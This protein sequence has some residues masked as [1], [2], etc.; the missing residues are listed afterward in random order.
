MGSTKKKAV[1]KSERFTETQNQETLKKAST[2]T[3]ESVVDA[4]TKAQVAIS[5]KLSEVN[6][7]LQTQLAELN[8]VSQAVEVKN[9]ELETIYSKEQ[10]LKNIDELTVEF[11]QHQQNIED[12]KLALSREREQEEADF[13]F[14][15][16]QLRKTEQVQYE[17]ERR[18]LKNAHRDE[19]EARNKAFQLRE[20]T[21]KKQ[22]QEVV[23][24]RAKVAAF[25]AELDAAVKKA[26][27]IV[28]NSVKRDYEHKLALLQKDFDTANTVHNNTVANLNTRLAANDK[29]ITELTAQLTAAQAK[30][31]DIAKEA[32]TSASSTKTLSEFQNMLASQ[33][34]NGQSARKA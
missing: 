22:E 15:R 4:V 16:E 6:A 9:A 27:A 28:G 13:Q 26:E 23:D 24:L 12:Q 17:E 33:A 29:V 18:L 7:Q 19:D 3:I 30:V 8:T 34:P 10:V 25:P 20:E 14:Q 2:K 11:Q 1:A 21:L 31:A 5:N 32:L